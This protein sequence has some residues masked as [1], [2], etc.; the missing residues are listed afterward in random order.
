VNRLTGVA[1]LA[2][3]ATM[4]LDTLSGMKAA[5]A[6][7]RETGFVEVAPHYIKPIPGAHHLK[8]AL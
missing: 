7:Y 4:L 8:A 1:R 6:L 2:G 5:R 3:Y